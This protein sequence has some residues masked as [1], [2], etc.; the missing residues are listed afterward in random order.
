MELQEFRIGQNVQVKVSNKWYKLLSFTDGTYGIKREVKKPFNPYFI[1]DV[2]ET[3][4]IN[5]FYSN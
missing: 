1:F 5:K 3:E 2:L 4:K